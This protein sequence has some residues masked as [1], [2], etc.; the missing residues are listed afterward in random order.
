MAEILN[1][2][3]RA[4]WGELAFG[5]GTVPVNITAPAAAP[6]GPPKAAPVRAI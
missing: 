6:A 3:G 4:G 2:W 5:Q 1:G